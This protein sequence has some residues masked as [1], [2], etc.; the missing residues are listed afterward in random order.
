VKERK[1]LT[2]S[3]N[4]ADS[5]APKTDKL[6]AMKDDAEKFHA[7]NTQGARTTRPAGAIKSVTSCRGDKAASPE[8]VGFRAVWKARRL[9]DGSGGRGSSPF[10]ERPLCSEK[11]GGQAGKQGPRVD[12]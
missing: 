7:A 6:G 4:Y 2:V 8:G 12:P 9:L 11:E 5:E 10:G 3:V 1:A